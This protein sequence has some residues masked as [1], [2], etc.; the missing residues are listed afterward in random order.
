MKFINERR[1]DGRVRLL[2]FAAMLRALFAATGIVVG[3]HDANPA[4]GWVV[5]ALAGIVGAVAFAA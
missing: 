2:Q 5:P 3:I 4:A 1:L